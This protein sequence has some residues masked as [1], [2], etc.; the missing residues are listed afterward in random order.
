MIPHTHIPL[1]AK[2]SSQ[3]DPVQTSA[4]AYSLIYGDPLI[5]ALVIL[6]GLSALFTVLGAAAY[7]AE[8]W[9][10]WRERRRGKLS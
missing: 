3:A 1:G 5:G 2:L 10:S 6:A 9:M 8:A 7:L 4:A